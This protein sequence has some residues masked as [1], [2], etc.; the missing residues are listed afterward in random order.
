MKD[1]STIDYL[2]T[3]GGEGMANNHA[4]PLESTQY[5]M[6][7]AFNPSSTPVV[8]NQVEDDGVVVFVM[9]SKNA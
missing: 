1:K 4:I 6:E 5:E 3:A 8:I 9:G 7:K 2:N